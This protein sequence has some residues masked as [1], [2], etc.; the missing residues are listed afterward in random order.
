MAWQDIILTVCILS[1]SYALIPQIYSGFREKKGLINFQTSLITT[2]GM[3][4]IAFTYLT[5]DLIFSMI[6]ATL[7]GSFWLILLI[8]RIIYD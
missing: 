5:L 7:A 2:L 8:Q 4:I 3:Y 1:F 6:M